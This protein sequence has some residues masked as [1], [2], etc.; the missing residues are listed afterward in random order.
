[1][2]IDIY[3]VASGWSSC[4]TV[5]IMNPSNPGNPDDGTG[6]MAMDTM[7]LLI[8]VAIIAV[9]IPFSIL[10]VTKK[11]RKTSAA[12]SRRANEL[13]PPLGR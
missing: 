8:L 1:M 5:V 10:L 11:R 2:A 12:K 7:T 13:N 4:L 9:A 6:Q 3:G